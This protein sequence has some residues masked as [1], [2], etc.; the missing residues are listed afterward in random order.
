MQEKEIRKTAR[1][2]SEAEMAEVVLNTKQLLDR[3]PKR[4][5][6]LPPLKDPKMPNYETVQINGYTYTIMRG[7]EVEVP[8]EV[9]N[10]LDRA[11]II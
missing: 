5:V 10:I 4:R 11:G 8:E 1:I 9:W 3:Q 7:P 6:K 2:Q